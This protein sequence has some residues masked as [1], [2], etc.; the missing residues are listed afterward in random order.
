MA[1]QMEAPAPKTVQELVFEGEEIPEKYIQK[2]HGGL[3]NDALPYLEIPSID[4]GLLVS[5]SNSA[6][7]ELQKLRSALSSWGCFQVRK[8]KKLFT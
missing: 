7:D 1:A 4:I 5:S 3:T 8:P 2:V 6:A